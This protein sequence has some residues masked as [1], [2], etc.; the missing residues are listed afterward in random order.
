M[1]QSLDFDYGF[2]HSSNDQLDC[3]SST[4]SN[5]QKEV[6]HSS[7]PAKNGGVQKGPYEFLYLSHSGES[8]DQQPMTK[9]TADVE[10]KG[11]NDYIIMNAPITMPENYDDKIVR[12]AN[13]HRKLRRSKDGF[14]NSENE[15]VC[16]LIL[17]VL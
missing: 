13:P 17:R 7:K 8:E 10:K 12:V 15:Y 5:H 1:S 2:H 4:S 9:K 11:D 14:S 3:S 6:K 16:S